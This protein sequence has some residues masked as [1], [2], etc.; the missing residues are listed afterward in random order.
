MKKNVP[1]AVDLAV[2]GQ[3]I[4][5]GQPAAN[6]ERSLQR[7]P[8]QPA[9][10]VPLACKLGLHNWLSIPRDATGE[11]TFIMLVGPKYAESAL[12]QAGH[13]RV[14]LVCGRQDKHFTTALQAVQAMR[15]G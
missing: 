4:D 1:R 11:S 10:Q 13:D 15:E 7:Q 8:C 12:S 14:C 2:V 9:P 5:S 6:D 3:A